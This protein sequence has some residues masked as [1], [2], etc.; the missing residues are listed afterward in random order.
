MIWGD[1]MLKKVLAIS[2]ITLMC[3]SIFTAGIPHNEVLSDRF[4]TMDSGAA[5]RVQIT[6]PTFIMSADEVVTFTAKLYDSVNSEV[7][8]NIFWSSTNGTITAEGTFYPWNSGVIT[9]QARH[10]NLTDE[11]N[12][13]VTP[14]IGQSLEISIAEG[15]VL[16]NNILTANLLDARGNPNPTDQAAWSIDGEY[17]GQGNP[18]WIPLD[19]GIYHLTARLYQMEATASVVVAAGSPYQF[20]FAEDIVIRSGSP[21][22]LEPTLVD[23]NGYSMDSNLAG[24]QLWFVENGSINN[25]GFYYASHPGLWNVTVSAGPIS[26]TGTIRV[27][28][29]DATASSLSIIPNEPVYIAGEMYEV[30][31]YRTDNLGFSGLITPPINNF[32]V[33]SGTLSED[34]GRVYWTPMTMGSHSLSVDDSGIISTTTVTVVH[35]L[36]IDTRVVM[37]PHK[38]AVG[39][40]ST[41]VVQAYDLAGNTWNV[42]GTV[43][44]LI[45]NSSAL[46]RQGDFYTLVPEVVG[47]FAVKGTWFDNVS[48]ILFESQLIEQVGFG[49]LAKIELNGQGER[50]PIDKPFDLNPRFFDT[51]G[52]ELSDISVNWT[53]D[54]EDQ[55]LAMSLLDYFW[56]PTTIGSHEIQANA[57][58]VF[59]VVSLTV[60]AGEARQIITSFDSGFEAESG[61]EIDIFI[62]ISDSRGNLAPA[63]TVS[64]NINA[65]VGEFTPSIAGRGYWTFTGNVSGEYSLT[66][67]QDDA[68]HTIS[69]SVSPGQAVQIFGEIES[70]N[71]KQGDIALLRVYGVDINNNRVSVIPENTTISCTSGSDSFV[72]TD[73]WEL[74]ISKS[75]LDRSCSIKWNGLVTQAFFDVESVLLGGAVGSTNTAMSIAAI[76]LGLI[77]TTMVVLVRRANYEPDE[78]EWLDEY[79]EDDYYEDEED[80]DSMEVPSK[81]PAPQNIPAPTPQIPINNTPRLAP[82]EITRLSVEAGRLGV[83]QAIDPSLQGASGW[84]V[85]VSGEVQYWNVAADGS[86]NRTA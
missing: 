24:S 12:I 76:L 36:A 78:T 66:F 18:V 19:T 43:E 6:P 55:T 26:G 15:Q 82:A 21:L 79:D 31:A 33:S 28:P 56:I 74:D 40:Q 58:G 57:A 39:Q 67:A 13:T 29:A 3:A 41:V 10:T 46:V 45:G 60:A 75:G 71:Y 35:G 47:A 54:G 30:A 65:S 7:A 59:S 5:V 14:G 1:L 34:N 22:Q 38:L 85:D 52:N 11:F 84:Y 62:Q 8:G 51:Y 70:R 72:T 37:T 61:V 86:W 23:A 25:T 68:Q 69:L 80:I 42:N 83:M 2:I 48:G 81:P 53:I 64:T 4:E 20:I 44:V 17:F 73:T 49:A 32:T 77:L 16:Q 9:I 50:I 63:E 27:V